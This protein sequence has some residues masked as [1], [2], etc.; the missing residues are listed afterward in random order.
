MSESR[1]VWADTSWVTHC[2]SQARAAVLASYATTAT[3][4]KDSLHV[5]FTQPW[6]LLLVLCVWKWECEVAVR[7]HQP[8]IKHRSYLHTWHL[9][10][11][12]L[13]FFPKHTMC[14]YYP[15][16]LGWD[17]CKGAKG[18]VWFLQQANT[19]FPQ[20]DVVSLFSKFYNDK[21]KAITKVTLNF[22]K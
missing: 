10:E 20:W 13:S 21:D 19:D 2:C 9:L 16:N 8:K 6:R 17:N 3:E 11:F 18:T 4:D 7:P 12:T 1:H 5:V 15:F 22:N 14:V